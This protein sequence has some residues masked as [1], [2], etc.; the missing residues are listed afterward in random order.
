MPVSR[1]RIAVLG[2]SGYTGAELLRLLSAHPQFEIAAITA[3]RKAGLPLAEVFPHLGH[4]G[5]TLTRIEELP[6]EEIDLVFAALPHGATQ[7]LVS[8][9]P[10]RLKV[11]DLSA[12]FRL[13]D[14]AAYERWYGAPHQATALQAEAAY[15]LPEFYRE[16]IAAARV[17]ANTGCYVATSLLAL[18]PLLQAGVIAA[19]PIV[20]DAKSGVSGAG[21]AAKEATLFCEVAEGFHAY[22][23]GGHRH[24][25]EIDQELSKA[26]GAP[27]TASF[28]PHLIPQ[29]R[30]I[31]AT[32]YVRGAPEAIHEALAA[33]YEAERFI[34]VRPFGEAPQTRHVR[35]SN[36]AHIGVVPDRLE[37]R[38]IVLAT[39][40]NLVKGASGQAIQCANLMCGLD[41][42]AGLMQAPLFP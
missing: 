41:E 38:A 4:L 22:G 5:M 39:L 15:G 42:T 29:N 27:V 32:I 3:D 6:I 33:R 14:P 35:G 28:T 2:A 19:D 37:G 13:E 10:D 11:V 7:G 34:R 20:I 24:M 26:A 16:Q 23:V 8:A 25:A 36:F 30:G 40:D 9:W 21:R 18:L 31:L 12:D 17:T 1:P